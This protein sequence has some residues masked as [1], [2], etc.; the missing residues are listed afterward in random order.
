MTRFILLFFLCSSSLSLFAQ[1][2]EFTRQ[3]TLRGSITP[4]RAWWKLQYYHLTVAVHPE[5]SS[6]SGT[7]L[8]RYQVLDTPLEMQIDLQPPMRIDKILQ[9]RK[10][11]DFR[12]NGNAWYVKMPPQEVGQMQEVEVHFSGQPTVA[13]RPPWDGGLSWDKDEDGN[14][15]IVTTC[16]GDGASL[17][18]PCKDHLYEEPDSMLISVNVPDHL[19]DVSNGRLREVRQHR[20]GTKTFHW[21]VSKPISNYVIN[22]NIGNY[23]HFSEVYEGE[24][25]PLDC[26]YY[27][28]PYNLEKAKQQFKEVPRMFESFEHWF[29]PYPFYTDGYK[30]VDVPYPGMEHQ[31]SVT[32]GNYY[33]NGYRGRDVSQTGI[34]FQFDFIIVHESGHEWFANNITYKDIADMWIHESFTAYSENLFVDYH[35][36]KAA[37][38]QYVRGTRANIN[39]DRPI[40]G[41]YHVNHSGSGDMYPKGANMLHTLRQLVDDDEKWRTILRGMNETFAYQTVN[42]KQI[43]DYLNAHTEQDLS[44]FFDQY[45]RDIR[46]PIL[47]YTFRQNRLAFR[48]INCIPGFDMP[49][50]VVIN[51]K[52][53]W[54]IPKTHW[55]EI[56]TESAE[57]VLEVDPNFYIGVMKDN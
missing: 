26:D 54:L 49:V 27:V 4:E 39:H 7:N 50:N 48:W 30:L 22:L 9:G 21:F 1:L 46:V 37:S 35:F 51:G 36:G 8:I 19:M 38:G 32:Y 12:Q 3:D 5:D 53:Q 20:D 47:E 28:L 13:A 6:L 14:D 33:A 52:A 31:S 43:E 23:T 44:A 45:L 17:W 41:P 56:R 11:L 25:G 34:G 2:P 16:Q 29:G 15:W 10:K 57:Q 18:W 40:Q 42:G 24:K 55:T